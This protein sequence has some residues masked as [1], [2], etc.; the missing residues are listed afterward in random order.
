MGDSLAEDYTL[1]YIRRRESQQI[2]KDR[3]SSHAAVQTPLTN[4]PFLNKRGRPSACPFSLIHL[5]HYHF[6]IGNSFG[7]FQSFIFC[8]HGAR[9]TNSSC[10]RGTGGWHTHMGSNSSFTLSMK[11]W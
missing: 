3:D 6:G 2:A 10:A 1:A 7:V 8:I 5:P 9:S 11:M 4:P